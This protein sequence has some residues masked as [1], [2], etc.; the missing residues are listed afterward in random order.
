M[1]RQTAPPGTSRVLPTRWNCSAVVWD[2][3]ELVDEPQA[4]EP[5]ESKT[6]RR[7]WPRVIVICVVFIIAIALIAHFYES[8]KPAKANAVPP[9]MPVVVATARTGNMPIYLTGLGSVTALNTVTVRSR[10]DGELFNV[11]VREGQMVTA[12]QLI[13][14]IDPR[15]FEVQL[16]QAQGL[17]CLQPWTGLSGPCSLLATA[18]RNGLVRPTSPNLSAAHFVFQPPLTVSFSFMVA[19]TLRYLRV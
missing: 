5:I 1:H 15:P 16:I 17:P 10:V 6:R 19:L 8:D 12:G 18:A 13:A 3:E 2:E 7:L 11:T 14:E 4:S 9:A